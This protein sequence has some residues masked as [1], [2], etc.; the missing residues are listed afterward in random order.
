MDIKRKKEIETEKQKRK[1]EVIAAAVEVFKE[2][3]IENSKMTDIAEKAK[4]GVASVYRYFK[5]KPELAIEAAVKFWEEEIEL[6]YDKYVNESFEKLNGLER[7]EK[8][9]GVFRVLYINHQDFIR[10]VEEFDNYI[11]KEKIS[12]E[13]LDVYENNIIG[14]K[15]TMLEALSAGKKD[16]SIAENI[17]G[18]SFYITITHT[19]MCLCQKLVLRGNIIKSDKDIKA[20]DQIELVIAMGLSFIKNK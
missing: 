12:A 19:L 17:D 20:E 8:I 4:V 5:T 7:V 1:E 3:G 15:K 11:V 9:L 18:E 14:L 13:R 6:L 16:G 2:K 10:F